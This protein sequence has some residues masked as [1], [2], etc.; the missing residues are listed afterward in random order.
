MSIPIGMFAFAS[1]AVCARI[2]FHRISMS[3]Y[4]YRNWHFDH[5]R[6]WYPFDLLR[7]SF[8]QAAVCLFVLCLMLKEKGND[9]Q[10]EVRTSRR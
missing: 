5:F 1:L 6:T 7:I 4:K 3:C 10:A 9:I 2:T 8:A